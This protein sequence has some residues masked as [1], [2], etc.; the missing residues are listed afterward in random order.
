MEGKT[1]IVIAHRLSTIRRRRRHLRDRGRH[2]RESAATHEELLKSGGLYAELYE[3]QF[4]KCRGSH[5]SVSTRYASLH[6]LR[7]NA[8][9]LQAS[10]PPARN[11]SRICSGERRASNCPSHLASARGTFLP[12][13]SR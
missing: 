3:L 7:E 5:R 12:I 9:F 8:P 11:A 6:Q 4:R 1:S 13:H 10:N 2:H